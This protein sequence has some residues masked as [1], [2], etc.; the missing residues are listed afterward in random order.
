M[1]FIITFFVL[2]HSTNGINLTLEKH[3]DS[4]PFSPMWFNDYKNET[5]SV[6][7]VA[8]NW[9]SAGLCSNLNNMLNTWV[10]SISVKE[11]KDI[12]LI[13]ECNGKDCFEKLKCENK[14]SGMRE[15]F[16]C[17]FNPISH[18]SLVQT[19]KNWEDNMFSENITD[20]FYFKTNNE[21]RNIE[22]SLRKFDIDHIG[23]LSVMAKYLWSNITPWMIKDMNYIKEINSVFEKEP[24]VAFHIRRGDK[25]ISNSALFHPVEAY[26]EKAVEYYEQDSVSIGVNDLKA[27]WVASDDSKVIEEV[28]RT[29]HKYFPNISKDSIIYASNGINGGVKTRNH[30]PTSSAGEYGPFVYIMSDI[31]Q[32]SRA[33]LFVGT[34]TSNVGRFVT[35]IREGLGKERNSTITLDKEWYAGR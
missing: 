16:G 23:A 25:V 28:Q 6:G 21:M 11:R 18:I 27:I 8:Y 4:K 12:S 17:L 33:D 26:L 13:H 32:L 22:N 5:G 29:C 14:S 34:L 35:L 10:W 9:R 19:K 24:F 2:F 3:N 20:E 15:G 1:F 7:S 31:D 30:V